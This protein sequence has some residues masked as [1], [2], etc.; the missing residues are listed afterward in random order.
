MHPHPPQLSPVLFP[1][2]NQEYATS[3]TRD[4][5]NT[6][7]RESSLVL[8]SVNR[9]NEISP[10]QG[11]NDRDGVDTSDVVHRRQN[12]VTSSRHAGEAFGLRKLHHSTPFISAAELRHFGGQVS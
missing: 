5:A 4:V 6:L 12:S 8:Y 3:V 7:Q 11:V 2:F 1:T 10:A 9:H